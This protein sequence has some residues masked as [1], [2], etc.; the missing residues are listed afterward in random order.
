MAMSKRSNRA[1]LQFWRVATRADVLV[2]LAGAIVSAGF[3]SWIAQQWTAV[4]GGSWPASIFIGVTFVAVLVLV[5]SGALIAW[6]YFKPIPRHLSPFDS[7][8]YSHDPAAG[9]PSREVYF[10]L[11]IL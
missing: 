1:W 7:Y 3:F 8:A 5:G 6:R 11:W 10:S 4:T 2:S 9:A